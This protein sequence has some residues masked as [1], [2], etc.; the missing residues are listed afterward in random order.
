[1]E[2]DEVAYSDPLRQGDVLVA[3]DTSVTPLRR[4]GIIIT[5]DCDLAHHKHRGV[6]N[7]VPLL[8]TL[9]YLA[10]GWLHEHIIDGQTQLTEE[11]C[12]LV[13]RAHKAAK[14]NG[15]GHL[16]NGRLREWVV[17]EEPCNIA[18]ALSMPTGTDRDRFL[19]LTTVLQAITKRD[20][21]LHSGQ[22]S[23]LSDLS[24]FGFGKSLSKI[25]QQLNDYMQRLPGDAFFLNGG[26]MLEEPGGYVCYLRLVQTVSD[27][28]V[29]LTN[30]ALRDGV[31]RPYRRIGRLRSPFVYA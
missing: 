24:R 31:D 13:R 7:F 19:E 23:N 20:N 29:S 1:V 25:S 17:E 21:T 16:S 6:L 5:A 27:S 10:M 4:M 11:V 14:G 2:I 22:L 18:D 26:A 9:D 28:D 30:S 3:K 8:C 15:T 12:R